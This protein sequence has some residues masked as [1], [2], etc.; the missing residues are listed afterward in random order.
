MHGKKESMNY[1][2][3]GAK[4]FS[5]WKWK[6]LNELRTQSE[7]IEVVRGRR[8]SCGKEFIYSSCDRVYQLLI[9]SIVIK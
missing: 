1:G 6:E 8:S 4:C 9:T 5:V 7:V 2:G 3:R